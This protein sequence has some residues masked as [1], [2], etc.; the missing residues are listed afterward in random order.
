MPKAGSDL[1]AQTGQE[2]YHLS[3]RTATGTGIARSQT[4]PRVREEL[5]EGRVPVGL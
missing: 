4:F 1:V 2:F 5:T 3:G